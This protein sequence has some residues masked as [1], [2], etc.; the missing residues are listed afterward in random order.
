[1]A[2]PTPTIDA[3]LNF[4][5]NCAEAMLFY[6]KALGGKI[7]MMMTFGQSPDP[8]MC[9]PGAEDRILHASLLVGEQRLLASDMG[10]GMTYE[11]MKG[12]GLAISY[13]GVDDAR[14]VFDTLATGGTVGMP[15][16]PTF[17][18]EAFGMVTDRFGTSWLVNGG[19]KAMGQ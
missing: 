17:W 16:G 12:F 3:Y 8:A 18:A 1:M 13:P 7:E 5:G 10:P 15:L 6:E 14:R 19:P 2:M 9:Q 11:G 4:N